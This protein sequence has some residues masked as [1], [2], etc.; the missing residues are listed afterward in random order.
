M[1]MSE[2]FFEFWND[3]STAVFILGRRVLTA[4][5][6][7]VVGKLL[8]A[9]AG[10]IIKR[11]VA[12]KIKFDETLG[13]MLK[14]IITYLVIIICA[15]MILD[16][17][18][19]NTTSLI[20]VLG[21]AGV[22]VGLALR[23]T[24]SNIAAGIILIFLRFY[25]KGDFI[26]FGSVMG[27]VR[28]MDL[29]TTTLETADGVY[30][31]APNSS[32]WGTPLKNYS[33]NPQRRM[34]LSVRIS[35]DDSIDA[36]FQVMQD[37]ITEEKRFLADPPPQI[38][39][40]SPGDSSITILLRAWAFSDVYWTVYWEQTKGL[41][42]KMEAAGLRIPYPRQDLAITGGIG[43]DDPEKRTS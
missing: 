10:R 36:A 43:R 23:D 7:A 40:Q 28:E 33:R 21:A 9:A 13:S 5:L 15:I 11:A 18:G 8:I 3:R 35:F 26:E 37:I 20:A 25:K 14:L 6:I 1:N 34:D 12:G 24:L 17:F 16:V 29:F 39:V 32:V 4:V 22:A 19:V 27:T 2:L 30:I 31:S 41:K 42:E 38:L